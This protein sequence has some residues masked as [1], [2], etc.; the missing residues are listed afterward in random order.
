MDEF[1]QQMGFEDAKEAH[2]L[3]A[4]V[5][6]S[7]PEGMTWFQHWKETDGT[8]TGLIATIE[9]IAKFKRTGLIR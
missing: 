8:K 3:I 5:D 7:S 4:S 2:R 6:I 1:Y 9:R